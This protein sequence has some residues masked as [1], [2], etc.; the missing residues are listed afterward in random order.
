MDYLIEM[1]INYLAAVRGL[2]ENTRDAY[3]RDLKKYLDFLACLSI[4]NIEDVQADSINQYRAYLRSQGL[5]ERSA[6]RHFYAIRGFHRYVCDEGMTECDPAGKL[7]AP[8][9]G[10]FL[11]GVMSSAQVETL[12]KQP[13]SVKA[14]HPQEHAVQLRDKAM[15]ETLY[16]SGVRVSELIALKLHALNWKKG[17][18]QCLGKG[19]KERIVPLGE[20]ALEWIARY[21]E[22]AREFFLMKRGYSEFLFVTRC[23]GK[24]SRQSFWMSLKKYLK[25]AGLPQDISPHTLRHSFATHLLENGADLRSLQL[26]LGHSDISTTQMYTH[27]SA[28]RL[29]KVY[30]DFHPRAK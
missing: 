7:E 21:L 20:T 11:P 15:L 24:M 16:A 27:V 6:A 30:D 25:L 26:M 14:R 19:D 3:A 17:C 28:K 2:S 10:S 13:M 23:G 22:D 5:S 8:K 4:V 9:M 18:I 1:Y 29:K 12:L